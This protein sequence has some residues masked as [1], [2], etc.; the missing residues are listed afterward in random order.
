MTND[1]F[2]RSFVATSYLLGRRGDALLEP[3]AE[4]SPAT[5]ELSARLREPSKA[6]RAQRLAGEIARLVAALHQRRIT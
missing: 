3:L 4:P 1:E 6:R 2:Q 5:L